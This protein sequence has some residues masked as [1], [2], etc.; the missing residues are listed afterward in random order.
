MCQGVR[1][2][3]GLLRFKR[4]R[5]FPRFDLLR[6][7]S[8][9][10]PSQIENGI[11]PSRCTDRR[12]EKAFVVQGFLCRSGNVLNPIREVPVGILVSY[13]TN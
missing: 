13:I 10:A 2:A 1:G 9:F 3:R 5:R 12:F 11:L 6:E 4:A 8:T 7:Q